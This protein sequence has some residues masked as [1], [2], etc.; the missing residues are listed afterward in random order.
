MENTGKHGG[1]RREKRAPGGGTAGQTRLKL[2]TGIAL[3]MITVTGCDEMVDPRDTKYE[4]QTALKYRALVPVVPVNTTITVTGAGSGGVFSLQRG[5]LILPAYSMAKYE[6]TW[7]LWNEVYGWAQS[8]GYSIAN[9]GVEG[10]GGND[11]TGGPLWAAA[12]KKTRPVTGVTWRDAV[13]WCNAYSEL[14]ALEPVYLAADGGILRSSDGDAGEVGV[15]ARRQ[16]N[17]FRLP[18]EAEW[19]CAARGGATGEDDWKVFT[20]PG[21]GQLAELAWYEENAALEGA[22]YGVHPAGGKKAL[23][24]GI[25]DMAGNVAEWCYDYFTETVTQETAP[26]GPASGTTRVIRGG[27]WDSPAASCTVKAR[28]AAAPGHSGNSLGFRVVRTVPDTG[29]TVNSG[30]Y[31][32]TLA[33][34]HWYWDSPWGYREIDFDTEDHALFTDPAEPP[35]LYHDTYTYNSAT[36]RG[37]ISG[38]Y[39]AG[40][41]QLRNN[42]RTM[43]FPQFRHFGHSVEFTREE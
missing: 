9:A 22:S 35:P 3:F 31:L 24:L 29:E 43:Y 6:T 2:L 26:D 25:F 36:G 21:G 27:A 39:P 16:N 15:T 10:H 1:A 12:V 30:D 33:G 41:F 20:Y 13:V 18:T 23:R 28:T 38:P 42:N 17:G 34:T 7:E 14:S 40:D 32:P 11:G 37:N 5:F 4:L 19:E 8:H